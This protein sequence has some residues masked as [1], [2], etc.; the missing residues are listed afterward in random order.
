MYII[1]MCLYLQPLYAFMSLDE[2]VENERHSLSN[3]ECLHL[4]TPCQCV[5]NV[6]SQT[7]VC[8]VC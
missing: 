2:P 3:T 4:A 8:A 7:P 6:T 1:Y 5:L